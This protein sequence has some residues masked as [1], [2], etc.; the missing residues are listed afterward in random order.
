MR[1]DQAVLR[2]ACC[3]KQETKSGT[4]SG[5]TGSRMESRD[6]KGNTGIMGIIGL[7]CLCVSLPLCPVFAGFDERRG[8]RL[9]IRRQKQS[10]SKRQRNGNAVGE[11]RPD[12]HRYS[13][14]VSEFVTV[15]SITCCA[16]SSALI[17]LLPPFALTLPES[18][19]PT[20]G[21]AVHSPHSRR[22]GDRKASD[23]SIIWFPVTRGGE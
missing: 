18:G 10:D 14:A 20:H 4:D 17:L 15:F 5:T 2:N 13:I 23:R 8:G 21:Q 6:K 12:W 1:A 16:S 9:L 7:L 11:E 3:D 22:S 19:I